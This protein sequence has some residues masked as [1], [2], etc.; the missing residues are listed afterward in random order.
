M[1][2]RSD[3]LAISSP[4]R[5]RTETLSFSL[6]RS[7]GVSEPTLQG[8]LTAS[9][10]QGSQLVVRCDSDMYTLIDEGHSHEALRLYLAPY[11][12]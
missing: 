1:V 6:K 8:V 4:K 2:Y 5:A 3:G 7:N 12:V 9:N 10:I 11:L